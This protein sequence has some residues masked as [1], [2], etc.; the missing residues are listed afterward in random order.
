MVIIQRRGRKRQKTDNKKE[1]SINDA[2]S[3]MFSTTYRHQHAF[4]HHQIYYTCF[5]KAKNIFLFMWKIHEQWELYSNNY[6]GSKTT[7]TSST[8]IS[9]LESTR[10]PLKWL[11]AK[12]NLDTS[13]KKQ[14]AGSSDRSH[15]KGQRLSSSSRVAVTGLESSKH[16]LIISKMVWLLQNFAPT[17]LFLN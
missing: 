5:Q 16:I 11:P 14:L 2:Q 12:R 15:Q 10:T 8:S 9:S 7:L 1:A 13:T 3:C 4:L 6:K 17:W